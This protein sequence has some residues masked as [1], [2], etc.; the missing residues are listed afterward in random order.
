M[1]PSGSSRSIHSRHPTN[2]VSQRNPA[3]AVPVVALAVARLRGTS[4]AEGLFRTPSLQRDEL[5]TRQDTSSFYVVRK[6]DRRVHRTPN[7]PCDRCEHA[8]QVLWRSTDAVA[9]RCTQC[10]R[11]HLMPLRSS[12]LRCP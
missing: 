1:V 7:A 11:V 2:R 5:T 10:F 9:F 4:L 8:T 3:I 12:R 6:P